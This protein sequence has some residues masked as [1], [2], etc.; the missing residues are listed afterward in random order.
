MTTLHTS[1]R[2]HF[3]EDKAFRMSCSVFPACIRQ[4]VCT[5][6][7][8]PSGLCSLV[9]RDY[10]HTSKRM[11]F[12]EDIKILRSGISLHIPCIRQNV[13]TS[14]RTLRQIR[15]V[16]RLANPCIRQNVCTSLRMIDHWTGPGWVVLAYV[17]TY[18]LH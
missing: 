14:L 2:M 6:L 17:K 11:H 10:L 4:N 3:I 13:C 7:R 9:S 16:V 1:K 15:H 18:A 5:S 8:T 12:I